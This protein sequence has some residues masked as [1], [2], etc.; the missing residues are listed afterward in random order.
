MSS[1]TLPSEL[2]GQPWFTL[3]DARRSGIPRRHIYQLRNEGSIEQLARG[4]Y[5][6]TDIIEADPSLIAAAALRPESTLC[7]TSALARHDL[8]DEIPRTN[9]LAL[10]RG[11]R[12]PKISGPIRWHSFDAD[13][14]E[15]G[16][17]EIEIGAGISMCLYSPERSIIDAFRLRGNEGHETA[18]EALKRWLRRPGSQ[19]STLL[20]MAQKFSRA[21]GPIRQALE[22]LL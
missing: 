1:S 16:R 9:D 14:F 8:T 2:R 5:Q 7:L 22:I 3:S 11:M 6:A 12:H 13:T 10:P 18:N 15:I 21:S 20:A 4:I 17:N 19:P